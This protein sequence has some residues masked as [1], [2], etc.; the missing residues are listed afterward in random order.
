MHAQWSGGA[1]R[2]VQGRAVRVEV[3]MG[4]GLPGLHLVGLAGAATRE[5]RERVFGALRE[6]GYR[7]PQGRATVNLAPAEDPKEGAAFDLG[8]ALGLLEVSGQLRRRRGDGWWV[9]GELTLD[10]TL[11]AVRGAIALGY[12]ARRCGAKGLILPRGNEGEAS[13]LEGIDIRLCSSLPEAVAW[14][15]GRA[16]LPAPR[17]TKGAVEA[18]R[19]RTHAP[20]DM[21]EI[22]GLP[23]LRRSLEIAAAGK[24]NLLLIG[25]PGNGKSL[26]ARILADL[27]PPLTR[28]ERREVLGIRSAAGLSVGGQI[29]RPFRAPHHSISSA[30]FLG[31]GGRTARPGEL[32][33]AHRGLLFLDELPEFN[34]TVREALREPLEDGFILLGRA[35]GSLRLPARFQLVAAMNPCP[36]GQRLRG[37]EFCRC[38]PQQVR[39]YFGRI[40][41]ALLDRIDLILEVPPWDGEQPDRGQAESTSQ[42]HGRVCQ[43]A[44]ILADRGRPGT[45]ASDLDWLDGQLRGAGA[46]FRLRLKVRAIAETVA[47]LGGRQAPIRADLVEAMGL[48]F[49][50]RRRLPELAGA[51]FPSGI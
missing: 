3:Q 47:A 4:R 15:E 21:S 48:A 18:D 16:D 10:G 32:S 28:E 24:H 44:G 30:G 34:R 35:W 25:P 11:A 31:G 13:L 51:A 43:A 46:S 2:G 26:L 45:A 33:L 17:F 50:L 1:L 22:E 42:V 36:C 37:E 8:I 12:A 27:L 9:L 14:V 40:S 19:K 49:S 41:G 29:R 7:L 23:S 38:R 39:N 20:L 6:C 5:S